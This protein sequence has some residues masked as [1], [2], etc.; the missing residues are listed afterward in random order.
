MRKIRRQ[1]SRLF[2]ELGEPR[3]LNLRSALSGNYRRAL[4]DCDEDDK[5][6]TI[7]V[8]IPGV[9]KEDIHLDVNENSV[10]I[11]AEKKREKKEGSKE[12]GDY[13]YERSYAGFYQEVSLP[14]NADTENIDAVYKNGVLKLTIPKKRIT[15]KKKKIKIK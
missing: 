7:E 2:H 9:D 5:N 3:A 10:I 11:R 13:R 4:V 6:F 12:K 8:E 14:E 1:M 15:I